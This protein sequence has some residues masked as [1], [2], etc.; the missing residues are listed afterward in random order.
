MKSKN[1]QYFYST[2]IAYSSNAYYDNYPYKNN[3]NFN[4]TNI[5]QL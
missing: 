1:Q 3:I 2:A 4:S 5:I